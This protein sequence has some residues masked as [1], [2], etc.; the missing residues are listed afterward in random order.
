MTEIGENN[1]KTE[2]IAIC[3]NFSYSLIYKMLG[4]SGGK[5]IKLKG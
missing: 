4:G 2:E 5:Q 3:S 1:Q